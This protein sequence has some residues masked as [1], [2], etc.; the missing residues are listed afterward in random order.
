MNRLETRIRDA[1]GPADAQFE[2]RVSETVSRLQSE[3]ERSSRRV[4]RRRAALVLALAILML[5]AGC[6]AAVQLWHPFLE[7]TARLQGNR[8]GFESWSF[9][10][11]LALVRA[12]EEEGLDTSAV[13]ELSCMTEKEADRALTAALETIWSGEIASPLVNIMERLKGLFDTWSLEEKAWYSQMLAENRLDGEETEIHLLPDATDM[14]A[15]GAIEH[16]RQLLLKMYENLTAEQIDE[17]AP[18]V[19][20]YKKRGDDDRRFWTVRFR[21]DSNAILYSVTMSRTGL[22]LEIYPTLRTQEEIDESESKAL[23]EQKLREEIEATQGPMITWSLEDKARA[24][25]ETYDL[26]REDELTEAEALRLAAQ[27]L[28]GERLDGLCAYAYFCDDGDGNRY[29]IV[30][31]VDSALSGVCSVSLDAATG[32]VLELHSADE[33]G[34]G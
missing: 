12:M 23:E 11:K 34:N 2:A 15:Q 22:P 21:D 27:A 14:S 29:Y 19:S 10:D 20:Y 28:S 4:H 17:L 25:P 33:G 32:R 18:C 26:P 1:F 24:Y 13:P 9:D 5:A 30:N 31:Y 8:G 16:A 7:T 3:S 6:V